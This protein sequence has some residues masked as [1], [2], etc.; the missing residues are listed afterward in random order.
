MK[1][2]TK[3]QFRRDGRLYSVPSDVT[4]DDIESFRRECKE[5]YGADIIYFQYEEKE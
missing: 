2:I 1:H 3:I 4:T 5:H